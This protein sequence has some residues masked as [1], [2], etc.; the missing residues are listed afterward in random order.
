MFFV[1]FLAPIFLYLRVA[2]FRTPRS[3][4][5]LTASSSPLRN[6]QQDPYHYRDPYHQRSPLFSPG[7]RY[8]WDGDRWVRNDGGFGGGLLLGII[9]AGMIVFMLLNY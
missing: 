1:Y 6:Y 5:H 8:I 9:T 3:G 2:S 7:K 4:S